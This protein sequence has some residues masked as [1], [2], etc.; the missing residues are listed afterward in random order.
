MLTLT[1]TPPPPPKQT[2]PHR[3]DEELCNIGAILPGDAGEDSLL[4]P[5]PTAAAAAAA[6]PPKNINNNTAPSRGGI[7]RDRSHPAR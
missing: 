4:T 7:L 2:T 3:L 1:A 5:T 6:P